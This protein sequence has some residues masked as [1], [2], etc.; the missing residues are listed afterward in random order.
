MMKFKIDE[1]LPDEIARDLRAVGHEADTVHDE[2][3]AGADDTAIMCRVQMEGRTILTMD[4]GIAN[5]HIYPPHQYAGI[6][7]FRPSLQGRSATLLFVR[8][9]LPTLLQQDLSGHLFIVSETGIRMR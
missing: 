9:H 6:I 2:G 4:K 8:Q 5:I 1:N 7:L 3:L